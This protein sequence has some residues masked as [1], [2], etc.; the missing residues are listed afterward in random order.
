MYIDNRKVVLKNTRFNPI[1]IFAEWECPEGEAL[2]KRAVNHC[3]KLS[4]FFELSVCERMAFLASLNYADTC[5]VKRV[6]Y[7]YRVKHGLGVIC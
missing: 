3:V 6:I 4:G 2:Y 7:D 1:S 5:A